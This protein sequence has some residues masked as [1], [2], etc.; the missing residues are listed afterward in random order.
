MFL[1]R[2]NSCVRNEPTFSPFGCIMFA[3]YTT[4]PGLLQVAS[5]AQTMSRQAREERTAVAFQTVAMV[6]MAIMGAAAAAHLVRDLLR[7]DS[8]RSRSR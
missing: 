6:S 1:R 7:H 5:Q 3:P 4:N 8:D 2:F